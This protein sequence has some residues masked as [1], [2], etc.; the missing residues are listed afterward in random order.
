MK[1]G[2]DVPTNSRYAHPGL[3]LEMAVEAEEAGWDGFF[4]WDHIALPGKRPQ[5]T[6]PWIALA[7]IAANTQRIRLGP[8]VT[9]PARRRPWKLARETVALDHL[10]NGRL[11]LGVG[12][13]AIGKTEF[14]AFG[15]ESDPKIRAEKLDEALSLLTAFWSGEKVNF[16]GE[17]YQVE[18]AVFQPVPEQQPRIPIWVGGYWPHKAP[19]R[20]AARWDGVFPLQTG[21]GSGRMM[22]PD[23]VRQIVRYVEEHRAVETPFD[24]VHWGLSSG[25]PADDRPLLQEYADAGVTWWLE[26]VNLGRGS[27]RQMRDRIRAG[28]LN[29]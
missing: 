5:L 13:G 10:S 16:K 3:L 26:N 21:L 24:I 12:L 15:E 28:P 7:A 20:R 4:L 1:F 6:D 9:P 17:H 2:V 19:M 29:T 27:V 23:V 11:V 18:G 25:D 8:M 14:A 22:A